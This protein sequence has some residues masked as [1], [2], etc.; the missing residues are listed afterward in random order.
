MSS[1]W[2]KLFANPPAPAND[3]EQSPY[4]DDAR[5]A[6]REATPKSQKVAR[7]F[8]AIGRRNE[9]LRAQLDAVEFSFR[10][11]EAIRARFHETLIPIDQTLAEIERTK[12]A[13]VEAERKF[14]ALTLEY[15]RVKGDY[16]ALALERSAFI[17]KQDDLRAR[18]GSL[19][20]AV[21]TAEA[22]SSEARATLAER[23]AK[24]KEIGR[25]FEDNRLSLQI[26]RN[27]P[28]RKSAFR[29]SSSSSQV[30]ATSTIC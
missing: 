10:D 19:E 23:T 7:T 14:E 18:I 6:R 29:T 21:T 22:A 12:I 20:R 11:I 26:A 30:C 27:P 17:V 3:A 1:V 8:D 28:P 5:N 13:H 25:E 9:D 24:L 2:R 4:R 16:A 15:G